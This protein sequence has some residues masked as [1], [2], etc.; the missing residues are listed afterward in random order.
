[1]ASKWV[2][3]ITRLLHGLI[4]SL[5]RLAPILRRLGELIDSLKALL[6][7]LAHGGDAGSTG[8]NAVRHGEDISILQTGGELRRPRSDFDFEVGWADDAYERIRASDEDIAAIAET[9]RG[10]GFSREDIEMIKGH[11]FR[12]EHLLDLYPPATT[13]RFDA[14]PRMAEAWTRLME[15]NAHPSD[16]DLLAHEKYE[17]EFM[18]NTGDP[19]YSRAHRAALEAGHTWDPEAAAADGLGYQLGG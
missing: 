3:R 14:N 2:A 9:A 10:R 7:R 11:V 13:E 5:R 4:N 17:A 16:F 18:R 6:R 1:L 15:G 19:S 8:S 12:G